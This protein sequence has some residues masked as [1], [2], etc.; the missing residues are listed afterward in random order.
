[1]F[2]RRSTSSSLTADKAGAH[3]LAVLIDILNCALPFIA[4]PIGASSVYL[5]VVGLKWAELSKADMSAPPL[6]AR[7]AAQGREH[8]R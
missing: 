1:L 7:I 2:A 3:A 6:P 4:A 8:Q 5:P